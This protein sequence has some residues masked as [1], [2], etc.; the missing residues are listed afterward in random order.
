M[1]RTTLRRAAIGATVLFLIGVLTA[2]EPASAAD[3]YPSRPVR[4]LVGFPPGGPTDI[5]ARLVGQKLTES[6]HQQFAVENRPGAG[7]NIAMSIAAKS[8]PDGYTLAV[9]SSAFAINPALY[10]DKVTYDP[11]KDF[12]PISN[13]VSSPTV[14]MVNPSVPATTMKELIAVIRAHPGKYGIATPSVGTTPDLAAELFLRTYKLDAVRVPFSGGAPAVESVLQGQTQIGF[15]AVPPVTPMIKAGKL[16][17]LAM[18]STHRCTTLPDVP[19]TT[20]AGIPDQESDTW[21]GFLAPAGTPAPI[22]ELLHQ[23]I[24]KA[25]ADPAIKA[26]L[27]ELGFE[28]VGNTPAEF[29]AEIRHDVGKWSKVVSEAHIKVQ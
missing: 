26:R 24:V 17:A 28:P 25:V 4:V 1:K 5:V 27:I 6:L 14:I 12:T 7:S 23:G 15:Q 29:A 10:G 13:A 3:D 19:T 9:D 16:R 18:G 21:F 2:A 20:E 22:I 11:F 8:A